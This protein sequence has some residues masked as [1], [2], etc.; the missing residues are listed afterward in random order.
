MTTRTEKP[1]QDSRDR[2]ARTGLPGQDIRVRTG[3]VATG[4]KKKRGRPEHDR[5]GRTV[6]T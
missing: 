2:I 6:G 3:L 4:L 5:K 1:E